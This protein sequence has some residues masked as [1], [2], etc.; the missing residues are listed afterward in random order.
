[1]LG[2]Q[3]G[4]P[5]SNRKNIPSRIYKQLIKDPEALAIMTA[6]IPEATKKW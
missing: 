1:M 5:N 2:L 4:T 3:R 6:S